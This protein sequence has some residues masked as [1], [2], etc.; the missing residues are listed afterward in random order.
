MSYMMLSRG[1][2]SL[3]DTQDDFLH[4]IF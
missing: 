4:E 1:F 3:N 2:C